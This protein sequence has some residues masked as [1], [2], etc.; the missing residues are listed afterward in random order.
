MITTIETSGF[1]EAEKA[2]AEIGSQ[3]TRRNVG[4]RAL[5]NAGE[6]MRARVASLAPTDELD[7]QKSIAIAARATGFGS[8]KGKRGGGGG[9]FGDVIEVFIGIDT[10]SIAENP[11]LNAYSVIQEFGKSLFDVNFAA[12]PY[13]RPGYDAEKLATIGRVASELKIETEKAAA[14]QSRKASRSGGAG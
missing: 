7:L 6:P 5:T 12:N 10:A 3:L 8:K 14:R 13:M 1:R 9:E 4:I 11:Q 2:L